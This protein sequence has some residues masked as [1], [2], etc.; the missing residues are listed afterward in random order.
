MKRVV[1]AMLLCLV[2]LAHA[3]HL[4]AAGQERKESQLS[5]LREQIARLDSVERDATAPA[6]VKDFNRTFLAER[7]AQLR[8]LLRQRI[9]ALQTY[10]A[11]A[12]AALRPDEV[13]AVKGSIGALEQELSG[14]DGDAP[15]PPPSEAAAPQPEARADVAQVPT[16]AEAAVPAGFRIPAAATDEQVSAPAGDEGPIVVANKFDDDAGRPV[17]NLKDASIDYRCKE[18]DDPNS[19]TLPACATCDGGG[20]CRPPMRLIEKTLKTTN[21]KIFSDAEYF[22][23]HVVKWK[24]A[25]D[26][27]APKFDVANDHWYLY[28]NNDG[29]WKEAQFTAKRIFGSRKIALLAVHVA[30]GPDSQEALDAIQ[31]ADIQYTYAVKGKRPTN[32]QHA[33]DLAGIILG[34]ARLASNNVLGGSWGGRLLTK[35]KEPADIDVKGVVALPKPSVPQAPT[36]N[37]NGKITDPSGN[38]LQSTDAKGNPIRPSVT[39]GGSAFLT[40]EVNVDGTYEFNGLTAGGHYTVTPS[41]NGHAFDLDYTFQFLSSNQTANF[42]GAPA[43]AGH[44]PK[45]MVINEHAAF[46]ARQ[47]GAGQQ[48]AQ[49]QQPLEFT[50]TYDNEGRAMWDVSVGLPAKGLKE[51]QYNAEDGT[52][53][54]REITRQNAYGFL[55]I[56][57]VPVDLKDERFPWFPHLVLGVPIS[58]KPLDRPVVGLGKGFNIQK[59]KFDLFVGGVFNRVREPRTLAAGETATQSE[60]ESDLRSRRVTK[61]IFGINLPVGQFKNALKK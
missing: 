4:P 37:I 23:I 24:K 11:R 10:L 19:T 36:H 44:A 56:F 55:N 61:L 53:R 8:S 38:S 35:I 31:A 26:A 32:I 51:L 22:V 34:G 40:K 1:P 21:D 29:K 57:P 16:Y 54:T 60:L 43:A 47:T 49:T 17:L 46:V 28:K 58:G 3:A 25:K 13:A 41:L 18:I 30:G 39:L 7:R 15:A 42:V 50:N 33:L 2:L 59:L 27:A 5:Q 48:T 9:S 12:D 14:L 45:P 6:E 20:H 52:I